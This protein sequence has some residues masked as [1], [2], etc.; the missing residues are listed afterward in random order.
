[1]FGIILYRPEKP[2]NVG[3]IIR[4]CSATKTPLFIIGPLTFKLNNESLK[5]AGLDYIQASS[6]QVFEN[7]EEFL[8]SFKDKNIYYIT[9]Y[10]KELYSGAK[11]SDPV[12]DTYFMFGSESSGIPHEILRK[13]LNKILRIPM[14]ASARSLNLSNS[15]AIVLYEAFRQ[16]NFYGLS[17]SEIIKGENFLINEKN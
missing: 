9:R 12:E 10:S 13:N 4:T 2:A 6:I 17:T 16:I 3:N 11:L 1:M 14:I 15:V 7:Y 8:L 5:R